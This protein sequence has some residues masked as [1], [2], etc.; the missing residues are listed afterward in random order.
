MPIFSVSDV[1]SYIKA[2]FEE[3]FRL[4]DLW[5]SGE[6]SNPSRASS[7]HLYFTLKDDN[8][9]MRCMMWRQ[10]VVSLPRLP[11]HGEAVVVHGRVSVYPTQGHYQLYVDAVQFT[12]VGALHARFEALKAALRDEGLFDRARPLPPFPRHIGVVTSPQAAAW[13]DVLTCLDRRWPLAQVTLA[14]SL[15][16]GVDAPA[17]LASALRALNMLP[18][19]DLIL[20]VRGGGSL[21]D[22]WAF[23]DEAVARAIWDCRVP[24]VSGVGHETDFTI[25]DFVADLRAPTPTA[26]AELVTPDRRALHRQVEDTT[27]V[28]ESVFEGLLSDKAEALDRLE[29]RLA[30][31]SP[32]RQ[33]AEHRRRV[34]DLVR[35][36]GQSVRHSVALARAQTDGRAARLAAL[37]PR[38]VLR[39]GYAIVTDSTSGQVIHSPRQVRPGQPLQVQ[40][41]DGAFETTVGR[42][43]K[44]F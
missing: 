3:D 2:L 4:Q 37:D 40:V 16:Q 44:L 32:E 29:G 17:M 8:A 24:V 39:R 10:Q 42:Q 21:E 7:G 30:R 43:R 26:A 5:L 41:E 13:R 31:L 36:A 9:Q 1:T 19:L 11:A 38:A 20:L 28:L 34:A 33:L 6:V 15:V 22:L 23:N 14:P 25:A 27:L 18:D 12:G 35:Q